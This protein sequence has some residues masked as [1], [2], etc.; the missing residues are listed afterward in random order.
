METDS[1]LE[2]SEP[3]WPC[4]HLDFGRLTFRIMREYISIALNHSV[5]GTFLTVASENTPR[6]LMCVDSLGK[7]FVPLRTSQMYLLIRP[8]S[9][10]YR[11]F[12]HEADCRSFKCLA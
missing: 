5:C 3:A 12:R 4:Q 2:L 8:H 6:E 9:F 11:I 10:Y 7:R 1:L